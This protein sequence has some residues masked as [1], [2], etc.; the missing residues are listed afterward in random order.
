MPCIALNQEGIYN[1][2]TFELVDE[3]QARSLDH[4][5]QRENKHVFSSEGCHLERND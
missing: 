1:Q 4:N 5:K 3:I 2:A